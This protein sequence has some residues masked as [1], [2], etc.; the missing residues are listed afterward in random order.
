MDRIMVPDDPENLGATSWKTVIEA[1]ALFEVLSKDCQAHFNQ[2]AET[3]FVSGPISEKIGP[4]D[5]NQYCD[6]VLNGT[7]DFE[8]FSDTM[9]VKEL[10]EGMRF[11]VPSDPT[12]EIDAEINYDGVSKAMAHTKERTSSPPSG[13]HYGHYR[14]LL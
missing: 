4:F 3:P 11:P 14:T 5:Q 10:I 8:E 12:P 9:E 6:E 13:R 7:F 1:Q 2:A